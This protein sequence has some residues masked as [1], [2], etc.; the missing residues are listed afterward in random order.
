MLAAI[1]SFPGR[2][3]VVAEFVTARRQ[4]AMPTHT[5]A[6]S[7]G[8]N[9]RH[10]TQPVISA[11]M[12]TMNVLLFDRLAVLAGEPIALGEFQQLADDVL[13][14]HG[15]GKSL[16]RIGVVGDRDGGVGGFDDFIHFDFP[17]CCWLLAAVRMS[18]RTPGGIGRARTGI[19]CTHRA[20][21]PARDAIPPQIQT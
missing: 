16:E 2:R 13:R 1:V 5:M 8:L 15:V 20:G 14:R 10:R 9:S 17:V 4:Q 6:C 3:I 18:P 11:C 19:R 21:F 7:T 12:P